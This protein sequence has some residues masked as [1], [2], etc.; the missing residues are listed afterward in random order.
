MDVASAV[1]AQCDGVGGIRTCHR[2]T[3]N[4]SD[5]VFGGFALVADP[6]IGMGYF[7]GPF[8]PPHRHHPHILLDCAQEKDQILRGVLKKCGFYA[9]IKNSGIFVHF[10]VLSIDNS[11]L[12]LDNLLVPVILVSSL[13]SSGQ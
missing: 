12:H 2:P 5:C 3:N 6:C 11:V 8:R 1:S 13:A 7:P 4:N 10:A 9:E